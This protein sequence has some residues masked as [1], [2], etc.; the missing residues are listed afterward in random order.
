MSSDVGSSLRGQVVLITGGAGYIGHQLALSCARVGAAEV[1]A[2]D[3]GF[4]PHVRRTL[5]ACACKSVCLSGDVRDASAVRAAC[6]GVTAV[7]ALA[8]YGMS[9]A[10]M[11]DSV[12]CDSVN[13]VG[14]QVLLEAAAAEALDRLRA[15]PPGAAAAAGAGGVRVVYMSSPNVVY[16]GDRIVAGDETLEYFPE[17]ERRSDEYSPSKARAERAVLAADAACDDDVGTIGALRTC[18]I[19]PGAIHGGHEV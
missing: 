4:A 6:V 8:G 9:G 11:L 17:S 10:P 14:T 3:R 18:A 12:G 2:F 13:V 7:I 5:D 16:G 1:R 15:E 19:R